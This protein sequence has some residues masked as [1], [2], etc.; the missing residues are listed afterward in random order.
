MAGPER[1]SPEIT[2]ASTELI[3]RVWSEWGIPIVSIP[4]HYYPADVE[5]LIVPSAAGDDAHAKALV[6]WAIDGVR[7]EIVTL[8]AF[9]HGRG[10]GSDLL[11]AAERECQ[12]RGVSEMMLMTTNDNA[13]ALG[14]YVRRGYRL[15]RLHHD[16]MDEVRRVKSHK[17]RE[18]IDGVDLR[19][20]WELRKAL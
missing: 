13:A 18:G 8:D 4:R 9:E 20:L 5:G 2:R 1:S 14:F 10:Y 6:T 3:E 19:D 12:S 17:T 11:A 16:A 15:M 7:A